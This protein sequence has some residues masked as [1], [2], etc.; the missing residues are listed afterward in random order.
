MLIQ[1]PRKKNPSLV[2]EQAKSPSEDMPNIGQP[3][4]TV[5]V[6]VDNA[7]LLRHMGPSPVQRIQD[8][9]EHEFA[10]HDPNENAPMKDLKP[11]GFAL[12]IIFSL[13]A[14]TLIVQ[15]ARWVF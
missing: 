13:I 3:V 11:L 15:L 8:R 6:T 4:D 14:W 7:D 9:L 12:A 1:K 2:R 10:A 5:L